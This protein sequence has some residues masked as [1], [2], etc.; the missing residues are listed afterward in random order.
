MT[1]KAT[2]PAAMVDD[3][4]TRSTQTFL[5]NLK[6]VNVV[7]AQALERAKRAAD[8]SHERIDHVLL[9]L[10]LVDEKTVINAWSQTLGV[11]VITVADF[12]DRP[13]LSTVLSARFLE[14]SGV[15][16]I[17]SGDGTIVV[18]TVD[19][20][21]EQ[22]IRAIAARTG[23]QAKQV[24]TTQSDLAAEFAR[25]YP[26]VR[27]N[28]NPDE[29]KASHIELVASDLTRLQDLAADS[30][31]I[32][33]LESII[34]RAVAGAASDIHLTISRNGPRLRYRIDG[35]LKDIE[36]PP[37]ELHASLI[38]RLKVLADL[39]IAERRIPQ[40]G[41]IRL[42]ICGRE[43]DLRIATMPHLDGEGAVLRI[44]DRVAAKLELQSLGF[45]ASTERTLFQIATEP[46][47]LFLVTGPTGSGK[48]TTLYALLQRL[49]QPE[50]NVVSVEDPIEYHLDGVA[51]IQVNR[52]TGL[53]FP[54][55]LRA[56]LRQDPDVIMVGEIRDRETAAIA[57]QS[58]LTGHFVLAT[59][60]TNSAAASLPRLNDM[61][62]EPYL[63]SST[64]RGVLAQ[65]LVRRL[66]QC[67]ARPAKGAELLQRMERMCGSEVEF[68]S[69]TIREPVGCDRCGFTGYQGRTVI[70]ELLIADNEI[71]DAVGKRADANHVARIAA[72]HG[73]TSIAQDGI[74][75]V[76]QGETSPGEL[77]RVIGEGS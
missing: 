25:L 21:D 11:P 32:L 42:G 73:F 26:D 31:A 3:A 58:A 56:V 33:M 34:E 29:G 67:C 7:S 76:I 51:Q 27:S 46:H 5:D 30:P 68:S 20:L 10:G 55:V 66:C 41:R 70:A 17:K 60:H 14:R 49:V 54:T 52:K 63:L 28:T 59:L 39:D 38:S 50:R 37:S 8:L 69:A 77:I 72:A 48:T 13:L 57:N 35:L 15:L 4:A 36:P 64:I 19:P 75:K 9:K 47:G 40:D 16:P 74:Q 53:D 24:L 44:L 22:S 1:A 23:L 2:A 18:A 43:I 6:A 45:S 12:P 61:G 71:R 62:L 65:R